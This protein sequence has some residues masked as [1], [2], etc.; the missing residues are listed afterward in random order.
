MSTGLIIIIFILIILVIVVLVWYFY[1]FRAIPTNA[2]KYGDNIK[3]VSNNSNKGSIVP[4]GDPD[5]PKCKSNVVI[6]ESNTQSNETWTVKSTSK[7][8]GSA[9]LYGDDVIFTSATD[10]NL[11]LCGMTPSS[12][13]GRD[14]GLSLGTDDTSLWTFQR[15]TTTTDT[16]T[17]NFVILNTDLLINSKSANMKLSVCGSVPECGINVTLRTDDPSSTNNRI[18]QVQTV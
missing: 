3:I 15:I 16:T 12:Q 10:G 18:W 13:C 1:F 5:D 9:V 2:L 7:K 8:N 11:F 6:R 4:C 14:V 17:N